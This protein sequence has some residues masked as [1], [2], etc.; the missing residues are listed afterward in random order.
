MLLRFRGGTVGSVTIS[1][2]AAGHLNDLRLAVDG[3]AGSA[4][5][6]QEHPDEL[7]IAGLAG[8]TEIVARARSALAPGADALA[9]LPAGHPEGWAD[10]MRNLLAAAYTA[11]R[12]ER[13]A[14]EEAA[15]PLPTFEDGARHMAFVEAVLR[16]HAS[17]QWTPIGDIVAEADMVTPTEVPS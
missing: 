8:T 15:A 13:P 16:S 3:E 17:G 1:Q 11:F 9:A 12:G 7:R 5:W 2:V 4:E 6:R 14:E 10:A